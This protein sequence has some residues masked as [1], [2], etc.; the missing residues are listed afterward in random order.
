LILYLARVPEDISNVMNEELLLSL[1]DT[2]SSL[3]TSFDDI[4]L[5]LISELVQEIKENTHTI[6]SKNVMRFVWQ[7]RKFT[8]TS[9]IN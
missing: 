7:V 1:F 5:I 9:F 8:F 3:K 2:F 4:S 6:I